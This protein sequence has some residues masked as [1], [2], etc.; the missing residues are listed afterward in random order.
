VTVVT[1]KFPEEWMTL[2]GRRIAVSDMDE[3]HVRAVLNMILKRRRLRARLRLEL[4]ALDEW[5]EECINDDA[6]WG[7]S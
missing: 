1:K 2:D 7:K 5:A 6:K 4:K 3:D